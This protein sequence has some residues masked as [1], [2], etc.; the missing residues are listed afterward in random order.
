MNIFEELIDELKQENLLETTVIEATVIEAKESEI[1]ET[2]YDAEDII[3]VQTA[4]GNND[5]GFENSETEQVI[6]DDIQT[7]ASENYSIPSDEPK[8]KDS[9]FTVADDFN[10]YPQTVALNNK[11]AFYQERAT[12]EVSSLQIVEHIL[13]GVE[14]EQMKVLPKSYNDLEVKKALH[15]FLQ[16]SQNSNSAEH[17][18]AEFQLMQETESWYSSLSHRD[19]HISVAHLR[20]YCENTRP[21]L[22]TQALTSLA[23]FYR[24]SPYS[25]SVRNKFDLVVTRLFSKEIGNDK[26]KVV[27]KRDELIKNLTGLYDEWSSISLYSTDEEDSE[28]LLAA[29]KFEDFMTEADNAESFDELIRNDFF[30]RL[31]LFK[32]STNEQLFAPLVAATAVESNVRIGN[33]YVELLNIEREKGEAQNLENKYGFL[34]DQ[35][36]SDATSKTLQLVEL[37]KD[38][39]E[40]VELLKD[41]KV[42]KTESVKQIKPVEKK[43]NTAKTNVKKIEEKRTEIFPIQINQEKIGSFS[44]N[45]IV[46]ALT[47]FIIL[48]SVG[49][50]VKSNYSSSAAVSPNAKKVNLENSS[51]KNFVKEANISNETFTGT[52]ES[53]WE[54][55]SKEKK[56]EILK[57]ILSIGDDKGFKKVQLQNETN[58]IV[59]S[60]TSDKLELF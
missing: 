18:Q 48:A 5:D 44:L 47:I 34:H 7:P 30:N 42:K 59:G 38:K 16:I 41:K 4:L 57:K 32:E 50:Y 19:K 53:S 56:E 55:L 26:R 27:L 1:A 39:K 9:N 14:R 22:S 25:E 36:I 2:I 21:A 11:P 10:D 20:R 13:S 45:K 60:A 52:V 54:T 15:S 58:K 24:N 33:R 17:A 51:L 6:L 12:L 23:R 35:V 37:L 8:I 31:R 49:F 46:L 40:L 43:E 3:E 29:F 28:V